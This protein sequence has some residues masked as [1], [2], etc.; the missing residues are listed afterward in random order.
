MDTIAE[1]Q[2]AQN[3]IIDGVLAVVG[4]VFVRFLSMLVVPLV[5][6]SLISGVSA[7]SDPKNSAASAARRSDCTC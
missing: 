1:Q 7:L 6:V 5:F 2:W 3:F 4:E